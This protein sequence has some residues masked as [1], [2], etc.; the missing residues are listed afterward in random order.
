M[1]GVLERGWVSICIRRDRVHD[2]EN[3][4]G[5]TDGPGTLNACIY[6]TDDLHYL[7]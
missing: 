3:G 5:S 2:L 6:S 7:L 1:I 4:L